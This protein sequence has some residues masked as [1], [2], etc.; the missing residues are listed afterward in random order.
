MTRAPSFFAVLLLSACAG[1]SLHRY[2]HE[3]AHIVSPLQSG[4]VQAN[5]V[6]VPA[7]QVEAA[8]GVAQGT[9]ADDAMITALD[10]S[11]IC[12][13]V[14]VRRI[15]EM[16][17]AQVPL[18]QYRVFLRA[19]QNVRDDAQVQDGTQMVTAVSGTRTRDVLTGYQ[20]VCTGYDRYGRCFGWSTQPTYQTVY[21]PAVYQ[22]ITQT[23][24]A[25]FANRGYVT[26]DT[27]EMEIFFVLPDRTDGVGFE[28][29][30]DA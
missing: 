13:Q 11:Q 6:S 15:A 17:D 3:T 1:S 28:W 9:L 26:P 29:R 22:V 16:R 25:C 30:F 27:N 12:V 14:T 5:T 10:A 23:G 4:G 2:P 21:D 7:P 24:T 8:F 18:G 20:N 19:N